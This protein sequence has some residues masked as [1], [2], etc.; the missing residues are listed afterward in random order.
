[1]MLSTTSANALISRER[2]NTNGS[3]SG[4]FSAEMIIA[5]VATTE[6]EDDEME[7]TG[8]RKR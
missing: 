4:T 3:G 7:R 1:M 5:T 2:G 8:K 6:L